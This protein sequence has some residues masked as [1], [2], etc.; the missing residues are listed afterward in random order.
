M[1][2]L[3]NTVSAT[4]VSGWSRATLYRKMRARQIRFIIR[5]GHRL[6]FLDS[7]PRLR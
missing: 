4:L 7:L 1:S 2:T 3:V 5:A 6:I